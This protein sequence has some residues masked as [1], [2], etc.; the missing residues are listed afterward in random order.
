VAARPEG[1]TAKSVVVL[2]RR[3]WVG[4]VRGKWIAYRT[5]IVERS[6][7]DAHRDRRGDGGETSDD[8]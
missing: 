4:A 8:S 6:L 7:R 3:L 5:R 2:R 1:Q